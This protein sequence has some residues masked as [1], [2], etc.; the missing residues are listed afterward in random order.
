MYNKLKKK[1]VNVCA[2]EKGGIYTSKSLSQHL[3][4]VAYNIRKS[5]IKY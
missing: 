4:H 3:I 5:E 1:T 2:D